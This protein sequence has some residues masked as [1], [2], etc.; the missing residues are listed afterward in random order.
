[1]AESSLESLD[2][3]Q[4]S[5]HDTLIRLESKVDTL[6]VDVKEMKDGT[7]TKIAALETRVESI[8]KVHEKIR[9]EESVKLL[10]EVVDWQKQYK[11]TWRLVIAMV[12]A[13]GAIVGFLTNLVVDFFKGS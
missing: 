8:E 5:D 12:S 6:I 10:G 9:P 4:R 1:M 3:L 7:S 11:L 2:R 13:I